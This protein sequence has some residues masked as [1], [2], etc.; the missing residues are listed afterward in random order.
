MAPSEPTLVNPA[1]L[2][3][4]GIPLT[5]KTTFCTKL[6][7]HLIIDMDGTSKFYKCN[8][9]VVK[10]FDQLMDV[11]GALEKLKPFPFK[12]LVIDSI[13]SLLLLCKP[14][15]TRAY[16]NTPMGLKNRVSD[17]LEVP[18]R[19]YS[20]LYEQFMS[21]I[22]DFSSLAERTIFLG[23]TKDKWT[24]ESAKILNI[25]TKQSVLKNLANEDVSTVL[26]L[27]GQLSNT[28][29]VTMHAVG[30]V[31]KGG[32]IEFTGGA[33]RYGAR[34]AHLRD[35]VI[36]MDWSKIYLEDKTT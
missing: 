33:D 5:G 34:C 30:L 19:G 10:E 24:D 1:K 18:F 32:K 22:N 17:V 16:N 21:V 31:R 7:S 3:L 4:Y 25:E 27:P 20:L 9:I 35:A 29:L 2:L 13:S 36:D 26:D 12:H 23:H 8:S 15:A 28:F 11:L 14:A 6:D